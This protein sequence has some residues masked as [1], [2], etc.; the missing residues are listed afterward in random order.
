MLQRI[1]CQCFDH[2]WQRRS[3]HAYAARSKQMQ[4]NKCAQKMEVSFCA[5]AWVTPQ[6]VELEEPDDGNQ[7]LRNQR[8]CSLHWCRQRQCS[9]KSTVAEKANSGPEAWGFQTICSDPQLDLI[10]HPP[11]LR[12]DSE[13]ADA[14]LCPLETPVSRRWLLNAG[15]KQAI[16][17]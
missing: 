15:A 11:S 7:R 16:P 12:S 2:G 17:Q 14:Q 3:M 6:F 13:A 5:C 8:P 10:S 9:N 4:P 1:A